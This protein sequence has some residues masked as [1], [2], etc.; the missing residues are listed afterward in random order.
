MSRSW[1]TRGVPGP[2]ERDPRLWIPRLYAVPSVRVDSAAKVQEQGGTDVVV[3]RNTRR[4]PTRKR[5]DPTVKNYHWGDLTRGLYEAYDR[6]SWPAIFADRDGLV[7]EG[8]GFNVFAV[9]DGALYTPARGVLL[10]ITRRT[11]I[12]IAQQLGLPVHTATSRLESCTAL[13]SCS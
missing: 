9:I 10:G 11:V 5:Y 8:A 4:R 7:T 1:V 12:E 2:G 3:A 13:T 6:D